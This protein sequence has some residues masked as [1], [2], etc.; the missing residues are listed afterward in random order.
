ML[1]LRSAS[2]TVDQSCWACRA[3]ARAVAIS[4]S[5]GDRAAGNLAAIDR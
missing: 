3:C 4:A 5:V 1:A 2:G